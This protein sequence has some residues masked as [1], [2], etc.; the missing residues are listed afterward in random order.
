MSDYTKEQMAQDVAKQR[1]EQRKLKVG[2]SGS[3][4]TS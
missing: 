4:R 2:L 3:Q 1:K